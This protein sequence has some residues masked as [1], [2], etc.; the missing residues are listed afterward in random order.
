LEK[1]YR[2]VGCINYASINGNLSKPTL[3]KKAIGNF[4]QRKNSFKRQH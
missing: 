1:E 3:Y 2:V 4:E